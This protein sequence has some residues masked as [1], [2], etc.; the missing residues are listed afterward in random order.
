MKRL[1]TYLVLPEENGLTVK[2]FLVKKGFSHSLLVELKRTE[3]G[4]LRNGKWMYFHQILLE[5]DQIMVMVNDPEPSR[6]IDPFPL[7]LS[8]VYEDED[9]I[10]VNKPANMPTHP[11][12]N[13]HDNTLAN[14]LA[15]YYKDADS[16][17]VFRCINRLDKDTSGL[18]IIA[19][20]PLSAAILYRDMKA[21]QMK[22]VYYAIVEGTTLPSG[23]IDIGISRVVGSTIER[24]ADP[25]DG[26]RAV[27]H[28]RTLDVNDTSSLVECTL[29]TGR[30]HQIRVH[31]SHLGHPLL[32]DYIYN[33]ENH[34]FSHQALHAGMLT[35]SHPITKKELHFTAPFPDEFKCLHTTPF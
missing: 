15:Y 3:N 8:I 35:F 6:H 28:Y 9:L 7:P 10:V 25:L 31:F 16:P 32:G 2:E 1:I 26:E 20:N 14:A 30:T 33:P 22:R 5:N 11:S 18:T 29:E 12:M 4:I 13:H 23:T 24:F 19:K 21:R 27:T 34:D 17:F